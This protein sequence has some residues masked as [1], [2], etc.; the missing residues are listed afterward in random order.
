V[1]RPLESRS[2]QSPDS[3]G[4]LSLR[5]AWGVADQ[6][7]FSL[8]S[9]ALAVE[10]A[11]T[12]PAAEFGAF[13][14]G[15]VL[16]TLALGTAEAFTAEVLVVRGSDLEPDRRRAML[17]E[18]CGVA[19]VVGAWCAV[20]VGLVAL[21]LG[22]MISSIVLP[23]FALAPALF[24]QDVSRFGFFVSGRPRSAVLNDAVW[25]ALMILGDLLLADGSASGF[26]WVWS[27]SGAV[28][29]LL[30]L[31]QSGVRPAVR[32]ITSW[33]KANGPTGGRFAGEYLALYGAGQ[34]VIVWVGLFAGLAASAGYRG[35][36]LMF[37]PLQVMLSAVRLAITPLLVRAR[38]D[39]PKI[40]RRRGLQ[41][42]A[43]GAVWAAVWAVILF[44]A[45]GPLG[46][47]FLGRSWAA[48]HSV[49]L[50][51]GALNIAL[52]VGFGAVVILRATRTIRQTFAI[53]MSGAVVVFIL[54][55]LAAP[56]GSAPALAA[57]TVGSVLTSAVLW[58]QALRVTT[59]TNA[60]HRRK[61]SFREVFS[62][63]GP[64][65]M[66]EPATRPAPAIQAPAKPRMTP[67]VFVIGAMRAGTTSFCAD[68]ANHPQIEL[69]RHKEP[70]VLVR[71]RNDLSLAATMYGEF[72]AGS[73]N[74]CRVD[75]STSYAMRPDFPD[76][77]QLARA[78]CP[79]AKIVY[80]VRNPVHRAISH[81]AHL[82]AW[83]ATGDELFEKALEIN[84]RLIEYGQYW[85]QLEPWLTAYGPGAIRVVRFEDYR[86]DRER[87]IRD[88]SGFLGVDPTETHVRA[89]V[90]LNRSTDAR[91]MRDPWRRFMI[92]G[93]Y[94]DRLRHRIPQSIRSHAR[95]VVLPRAPS[96]PKPSSAAV[97]HIIEATRDDARR[98]GEY[99]H[100]STPLWDFEETRRQFL[101]P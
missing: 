56:G 31:C 17:R 78:L 43:L 41:I 40:V 55:A 46:R 79:D 95:D 7:I 45:P 99:L 92:S 52:A 36:Q 93:L 44:F 19:G 4:Q 25:A 3:S 10:V 48:T 69:P 47:A 6:F 20:L 51:A 23:I 14:I 49:I 12:A 2:A 94:Q 87:V 68:L 88:V 100:A 83:D 32:P 96:I 21:L 59:P 57:V 39:R 77:A 11:H 18:A 50:Y 30:A 62:L 42:A 63:V 97:D 1:I 9:F 35:A 64:L 29:G 5:A 85:W 86:V 101:A 54:G 8:T 15:Y 58:R 72:F 65:E 71:C 84:R 80:L 70:W 91:A 33:I 34:G 90:V 13:G 37:G 66:S 38:G 89:D 22:G 28:C 73:G 98:L 60:S 24:I 61:M 26:A 27:G 81:Y 76:V 75:G 67:D 16:Y 74:A 53:R 82:R